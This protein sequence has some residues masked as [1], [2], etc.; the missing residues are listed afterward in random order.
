M[1]TITRKEQIEQ[2]LIVPS[3]K[4]VPSTIQPNIHDN[5]RGII[6]AAVDAASD[7][8]AH[9]QMSHFVRSDDDAVSQAKGS[10]LYSLAYALAAAMIT[11]GI[12]LMAWILRGGDG[13][14][15]GIAF[16]VIWGVCVLVALAVNRKQGLRHSSAGIALE[17]IASRE[18]MGM[19][20]IDKHVELIEKRWALDES[21]AKGQISRS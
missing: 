8:V 9:R 2:G 10:L 7:M 1:N 12:V 3:N 14:N 11:G 13:S 21:R 17:E 4:F 16:L 5:D 20:A 18:R 19:Y 6:Q 15:Y